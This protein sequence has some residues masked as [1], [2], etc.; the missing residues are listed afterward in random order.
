M[1]GDAAEIE[2]TFS[3]VGAQ[4]VAEGLAESRL[5]VALEVRMPPRI[6]VR[7]LAA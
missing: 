7:A 3:R 5:P 4:R 1:R 2:A 6:G